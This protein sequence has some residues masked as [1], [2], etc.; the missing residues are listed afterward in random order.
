MLKH[1]ATRPLVKGFMILIFVFLLLRAFLF[2]R[3]SAERRFVS[4]LSHFGLACSPLQFALLSASSVVAASALSFSRPTFRLA[5]QK[6]YYKRQKSFHDHVQSLDDT[7][8][9]HAAHHIPDA[10]RS[11]SYSAYYV[12]TLKTDRVRPYSYF[13]LCLVIFL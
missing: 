8:Y 6:M 2:F 3:P 11:L 12:S 1:M 9:V 10:S 7:L 13:F 4:L 5:V